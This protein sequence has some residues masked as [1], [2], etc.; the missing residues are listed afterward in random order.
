[1]SLYRPPCAANSRR[2]L[3][4]AVHT[5]VPP[6]TV[7]ASVNAVAQMTQKKRTAMCTMVQLR[8]K[9]VSHC[10]ARRVHKG[11][12]VAFEQDA[13]FLDHRAGCV[14]MFTKGDISRTSGKKNNTEDYDSMRLLGVLADVNHYPHSQQQRTTG[15]ASRTH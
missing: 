10:T 4:I 7:A 15:Q 8:P 9:N 2:S 11:E 13:E 5:A 1:V 3:K 14:F 12:R 6:Q